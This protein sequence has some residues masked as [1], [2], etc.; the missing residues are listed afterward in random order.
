M[1]TIGNL[2]FAL[3]GKNKRYDDDEE[4]GKL[5]KASKFARASAFFKKKDKKG[6]DVEVQHK[7]EKGWV[8][9]EDEKGNMKNAETGTVGIV[10][11][12]TNPNA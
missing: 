9:T 1:S 7:E 3:Q 10:G 2:T 5:Q 8:K 12:L 6:K 11:I 4:N